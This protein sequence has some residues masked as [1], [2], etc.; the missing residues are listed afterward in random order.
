MLKQAVALLLSLR[1]RMLSLCHTPPSRPGLSATVCYV[2]M[3]MLFVLSGCSKGQ[4]PV[5]QTPASVIR[6]I[7]AAD[8]LRVQTFTAEFLLSPN[9][10]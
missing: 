2:A 3:A 10:Y 6:V 8:G 4:A 9:G 1:L 5:L 7:P